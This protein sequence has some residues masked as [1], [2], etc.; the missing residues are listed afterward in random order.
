VGRK[1][2]LFVHGVSEKVNLRLVTAKGHAQLHAQSGDVEIAGNKNLRLYACK[3]KLIVIAEQ[4]LLL[5]CGGAYIRLKDGNIDL[6]AP[7]KVSAKAADV[8]VEGPTSMRLPP[9]Q[10]PEGDL[11]IECLLNA[12]K[13]NSP[14]A[15]I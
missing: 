13:A 8:P 11:C 2:S 6:H 4:E 9:L 15:A 7:G 3:E 5:A 12:L 10:F 1:I 14:L